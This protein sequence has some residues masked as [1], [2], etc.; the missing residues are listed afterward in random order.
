MITEP[1]G[2]FTLPGALTV[3]SGPQVLS[4]NRGSANPLFT[5][6]STQ[7]VIIN[8]TG[9]Q[10][11]TGSPLSVMFSGTG[12]TVTS[13]QFTS[14]SQI[15]AVVDVAAAAAL[16]PRT[17]TVVN[18]DFGTGVSASAILALATPPP[19]AP[20][21]LA[22]SST[23]STPP[24]APT[25]TSLTPTAGLLGSNVIL[26]GSGFSTTLTANSVTFAGFNGTRVPATVLTGATS[27]QL[28]VTVPANAT[29]GPVTVAVNGQVSTPQTF[30]VTSPRLSAAIP[31]SGAQGASL[32]IT[33]SGTKFATTRAPPV[34]VAFSGSGITTMTPTVAADGTAVTVPITISAGA[35][36]GPRSVTVTNST[37]GSSTLANAFTV[38]APQAAAFTFSVQNADPSLFLPS[39]DQVM[40][41]LDATGR[42]TAKT[43]TPHPVTLTATLVTGPGVTLQQ[44]PPSVTF[45]LTS[46][47]LPGPATNEDCELGPTPTNDF[48]FSATDP[49][50]QQTSVSGGGG[51]VYQTTLYS[52]DWGGSVQIRVTGIGAILN[53]V[54]QTVTSSQ[55]LPVDTDGDGLPD[56]Y[57]RD[58]ILGANALGT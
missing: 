55:I 24:A 18:P 42:C 56:A 19:D 29:D 22:P 27:T 11:P 38:T 6:V 2:T 10:P 14:S 46:S 12:I 1:S 8:G 50:L 4:T 20:V 58:P 39:V 57:D 35:A 48:S 15:A 3:T 44:A 34:T 5:N 9:F 7:T 31:G 21:G 40:V 49:G 30:T 41:T 16:T 23:S 25:L 37:G 33:L 54:T 52:W 36:L 13:V 26:V 32:S 43:I 17:V 53:G 28:T 51:V 45:T 47:A